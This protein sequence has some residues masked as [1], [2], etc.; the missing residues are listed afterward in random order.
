MEM[1]ESRLDFLQKDI[2]NQSNTSTNNFIDSEHYDKIEKTAVLAITQA[3]L[4][5]KSD[6]SLEVKNNSDAFDNTSKN[7]NFKFLSEKNISTLVY[8]DES[9]KMMVHIAQN[10]KKPLLTYSMVTNYR[11]IYVK[12]NFFL[13]MILLYL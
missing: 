2:Q 7:S 4:N 5:D 1:E 6:E 10:E 8:Q 13:K 12:G 9:K 3:I 11:A